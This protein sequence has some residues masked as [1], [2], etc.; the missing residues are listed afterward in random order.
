MKLYFWVRMFPISSIRCVTEQTPCS[1]KSWTK[2]RFYFKENQSISPQW[3]AVWWKKLCLYINVQF[4]TGLWKE[5]W[6]IIYKVKNHISKEAQHPKILKN[7]T[8]WFEPDQ[9]SFPK[10]CLEPL[11]F[12]VYCMALKSI[13][14]NLPSITGFTMF[15]FLI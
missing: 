5:P 2:Y 12:I 11:H 10:K 13:T 1:T 8:K 4:C 15:P 9:L 3:T 14:F 7:F 6:H